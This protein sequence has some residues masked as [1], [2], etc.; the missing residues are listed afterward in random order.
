[1]SYDVLVYGPLFCDL[2][3]TGLP[4]MPTLGTET[5]AGDFTIAIGGSAIVAAAL[6]RLGAKVGLIAEL[7]SD[8]LSLIAR[9]LT[10]SRPKNRP[11]YCW[12]ACRRSSLA[13]CPAG[14]RWSRQ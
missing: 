13:Q 14:R 3:F 1:V 4:A 2:I 5:F 12:P 8:P 7:G 11:R 10:Q 6:H 9:N